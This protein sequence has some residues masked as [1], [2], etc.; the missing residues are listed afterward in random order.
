MQRNA[1]SR[2]DSTIQEGTE[3]T[4]EEFRHILVALAL[5]GKSFQMFGND[6]IEGM[7]FRTTRPV[8][9]LGSREGI[10]DCKFLHKTPAQSGQQHALRR[11]KIRLDRD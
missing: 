4:F 5:P 8:D 9:V 11:G 1:H 10:S 6:T 7:L 2:K 3:L